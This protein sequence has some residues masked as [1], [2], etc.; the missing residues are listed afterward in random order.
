MYI[1]V[2]VTCFESMICW[3]VCNTLLFPSASLV[4]L[5]LR[6]HASTLARFHHSYSSRKLPEVLP[7]T[8]GEE[9][10]ACI[11]RMTV[12]NRTLGGFGWSTVAL[13]ENAYTERWNPLSLGAFTQLS[14]MKT[15]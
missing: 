3:A 14:K 13:M 10:N 7:A 8:L 6:Q 5:S 4:T 12:F 11:S 2:R 15:H 9:Q 1:K